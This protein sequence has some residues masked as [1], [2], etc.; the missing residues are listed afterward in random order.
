M[1]TLNFM[2]ENKYKKKFM[3]F[4]G[5]STDT[6]PTF[7]FDDLLIRNGSRLWQMDTN[8]KYIYD[9]QNLSWYEISS[10]S[11]S[12]GGGGSADSNIIMLEA[13]SS[14]TTQATGEISLHVEIQA[15]VREI[16]QYLENGKLVFYKGSYSDLSSKPETPIENIFSS[17]ILLYQDQSEYMGEDSYIIVTTTIN[18]NEQ[19]YTYF[20]CAS[21]DQ[22][23][24][25]IIAH[26]QPPK[27][28]D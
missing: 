3:K 4:I 20:E 2:E 18:P 1:I 21:L 23:P 5:L 14:Q 22:K 28:S 15:T 8:K 11:G 24:D 10:S 17:K 9:E 27:E 26:Y 7:S 25:V 19:S 13:E 16:K 6:K 12:G